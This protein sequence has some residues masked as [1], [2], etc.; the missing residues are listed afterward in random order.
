[1]SRRLNPNTRLVVASHN[2]G[3]VTEILTLVAPFGLKVASARQLGL[4]EPD[5]TGSSF[6]ENAELKAVAAAAASALP[7]LADDSGLEV[8]ALGG[9]PGIYSARWAGPGKDFGVAMQRVHDELA[10]RC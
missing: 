1:M 7:A 3:K 10:S 8:M 4:P 2:P 5:E 6:V 9:A